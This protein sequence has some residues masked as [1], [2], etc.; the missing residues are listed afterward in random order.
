MHSGRLRQEACTFSPASVPVLLADLVLGGA[1]AAALGSLTRSGL[2]G[3]LSLPWSFNPKPVT[4]DIVGSR[5]Q[6]GQSI[7]HLP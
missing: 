5:V 1:D 3:V 4:K 6:R 2:A 7:A